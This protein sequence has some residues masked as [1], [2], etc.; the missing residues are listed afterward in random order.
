MG[1][2][3]FKRPDRVVVIGKTHAAHM[4]QSSAPQRLRQL[5]RRLRRRLRLRRRC[6]QQQVLLLNPHEVQNPGREDERLVLREAY[7][8]PDGVNPE[9]L[10][11]VNYSAGTATAPPAGGRR[12]EADFDRAEVLAGSVRPHEVGEG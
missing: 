6:G 12:F 5:R 7:A 4:Q 11:W 9:G 10:G 2:M 8:F 3:A 1:D